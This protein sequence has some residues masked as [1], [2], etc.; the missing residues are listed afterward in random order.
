MSDTTAESPSPASSPAPAVPAADASSKVPVA[1]VQ[2]VYKTFADETGHERTVLEDVSLTIGSGEVVCIL[3]ESGCGKSTLLRIL[4]GLIPETKGNVIAHGKPLEGLHPGSAIVFQSFALYPWLT[5]RE[6]VAVGLNG[7]GLRDDEIEARTKRAI[8]LVGLEGYE[9]EYPKKL[10]GGMKQRVG[11]ARA[12]VGGPELLCMDE[13]FSALD[14]LTAESLR[15][16]VYRLW[17]EKEAGL[18]SVLMITHIIEEAVYL[19]DRIV[20]MDK[21]PGRVRT[22]IKN[23]L[24]HP[25]EYR[26]PAFLKLVERIHDIIVGFQLPD[27][28]Q[29]IR[30]TPLP[31]SA[32]Q[33]PPRTKPTPLPRVRVGEIT[34]LLEIIHDHGDAMDLFELDTITT[35][36]F[37]HTIAVVKAAELLALVTTPGDEVKITD[38]G[39]QFLA[40]DVNERKQVWRERVER[41]ATFKLVID[42]LSKRP[43]KRLP[44]EVVR[45]HLVI[46]LP[47]ERPKWVFE[48]ILNW[49]RYA[50]LFQYDSTIDE[51]VLVPHEAPA[52]PPAS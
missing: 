26:T 17:A 1:E 43:D 9:N 3:G 10:S 42:V 48:T 40:G 2:H 47:S 28:P 21:N 36:D 38:V 18:S 50:E 52:P 8:D 32:T 20:I 51:I 33:Q 25:R 6:N 16:E 4:V 39:K 29:E 35:Y 19:G 41:L 14:V 34:G 31:A 45:E 5:V 30:A 23:D 11:I 37:G 7:R 13:P 24:P 46:A 49:G 15:S 12:L 22:I 44:A 27:V